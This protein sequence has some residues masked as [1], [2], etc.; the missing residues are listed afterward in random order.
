MFSLNFALLRGGERPDPSRQSEPG[1]HYQSTT[2]FPTA[3]YPGTVGVLPGCA[4]NA[5]TCNIGT[6]T[7]PGISLQRG[8]GPNAKPQ[9]GNGYTIG[10][11][12]APSFLL[13][14][15]ANVT[16]WDAHFK[17][18]VTSPNASVLI[19]VPGLNYLFQIFPHGLPL[20]S[21]TV[22]AALA[23]YP[24]LNSALPSTVYEIVDA[25]QNNIEN[26]FAQGLD[27]TFAYD[28]DTNFGHFHFSEAATELTQY[29]ISF[30][31]PNMGPSY[32]LLNTDGQTSQFPEIQFQS[33]GK[34]G[35]STGPFT[36]NIFVNFMGAYRNWSG[37]SLLPL[38]RD[39]QNRCAA[40]RYRLRCSAWQ[41]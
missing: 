16:L 31:Y 10:V 21:P 41:S 7:T 6:A 11:D 30:G 33:R 37:T 26:L 28:F 22:Q 27:M 23:P 15:M 14:F 29:D 12:Y 39:E 17:G 38:T 2:S 3:L 5:A 8:I 9:Q 1:A 4:A 18:A 35:Y 32:S 40:S 19:Q 36:A 13:G 20:S 34:V 24:T 25:S